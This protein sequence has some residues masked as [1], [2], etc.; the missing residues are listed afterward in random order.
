VKHL[1]QDFHFSFWWTGRIS[2]IA[3]QEKSGSLP[4]HPVFRNRSP[5]HGNTFFCGNCYVF[6][7]GSVFLHLALLKPN[8]IVVG[9]DCPS[10]RLDFRRL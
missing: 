7:S 4:R 3:F 8:D 2:N 5:N 9:A 1:N 10:R 6:Y